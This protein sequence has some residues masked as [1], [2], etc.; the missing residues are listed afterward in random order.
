MIEIEQVS[1]TYPAGAKPAL[2]RLSL[3]VPAGQV[4]GVMGANGSGKSTLAGV[5]AGMVP[6]VSGGTL[7]G[8]VSVA[9]QAITETASPEAATLVGLVMQNPS[10]QM[11]GAKFTVLEEL[12]FGLENLGIPRTEMVSRIDRVVD[13]LGLG[14]LAGRPPFE[15]SG[16][17]QQMVAIG[18]ILVMA[19]AV[20]VLDEPT[21]QLDPDGAALIF[22]ALRAVKNDVTIVVVEHRV[23]Q[24]A[25][26]ADRVLVLDHGR[27]TL[28]GAPAEVLTHPTLDDLGVMRT[29]YTQAAQL[30]VAESLWPSSRPL[31]VL[32]PDTVRGFAEVLTSDSREFS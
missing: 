12:A 21:S 25:E 4:C 17:Q 26:L 13:L 27:I 6:R 2:S 19:P 22:D 9:G 28:D 11:S 15:L 3:S 31:P 18:S 8:T 16:G 1:F 30:A 23:E 24:L 29:R 7:T 14:R 5:I 20:L 10:S 32:L